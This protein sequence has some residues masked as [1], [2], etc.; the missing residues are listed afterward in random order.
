[1]SDHR[2]NPF[3]APLQPASLLRRYK[4][5]LADLELEDGTQILAHCPNSG[6][7]LGMKEPGSPCYVRPVD[8]PKRK[9]K[10]TWELVSPDQ[11]ATWV[12]MNTQRPNQVVEWAIQEGLIPG[13]SAEAGLRREV[14][15]GREGRSRIDLL[16]GN[17]EAGLTY[18]EVKNTT[19]AED[20]LARFPDAVTARGAKHMDEL[21]HVVEEGHR[22][23]VVFFVNRADCDRFDVARDI[24]SAYGEAF[25]RAVAAGVQIVPLGMKVGPQGWRV[26]ERLPMLAAA[27]PR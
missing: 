21:V 9:L 14:K 23:A 22:A 3:E 8:D 15:Y 19:L 4:R 10:W 26:R 20:G 16:L 17:K 1:M 12:G 18:V 13:L 11:G 7:M 2:F 25:D 5:F 27:I 6:S 24:D